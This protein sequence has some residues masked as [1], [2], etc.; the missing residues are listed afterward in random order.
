MRAE[1]ASRAHDHFV[2]CL[3][4]VRV[5]WEQEEE[6][7]EYLQL[8]II[9]RLALNPARLF[10]WD[11][12]VKASG[13][14]VRW[15]RSGTSKLMLGRDAQLPPQRRLVVWNLLSSDGGRISSTKAVVGDEKGS[16]VK[17]R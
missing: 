11:K 16:C 1:S 13:C 10:P 2:V 17:P 9:S 12:R 5:N 6:V 3:F 15:H 8:I 7:T 4:M 14:T